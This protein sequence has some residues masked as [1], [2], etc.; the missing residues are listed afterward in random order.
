M[1]QRGGEVSVTVHDQ[2]VSLPREKTTRSTHLAVCESIWGAEN[3]GS[4]GNSG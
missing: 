4:N 3:E 2:P 1:W